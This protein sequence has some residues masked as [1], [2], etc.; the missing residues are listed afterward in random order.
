MDNENR[1]VLKA[2]GSTEET[3]FKEFCRAL[4]DDCPQNTK[5]WAEMFKRIRMLEEGGMLKVFR[6]SGGSTDGFIL[7]EQGANLIRDEMDAGRG[8]LQ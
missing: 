6:T 5:E 2:I 7:T 4:A 1:K 8:L 3:T